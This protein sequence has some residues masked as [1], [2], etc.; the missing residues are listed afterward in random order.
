MYNTKISPLKFCQKTLQIIL[1]TKIGSLKFSAQIES[2]RLDLR[3]FCFAFR[4]A[5][6]CVRLGDLSQAEKEK[7][8]NDQFEMLSEAFR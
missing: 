6:N 1:A 2:F 7:H 8:L 4:E 3:H 5:S